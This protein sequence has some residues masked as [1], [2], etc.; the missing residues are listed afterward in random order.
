MELGDYWPYKLNPPENFLRRLENF[1]KKFKMKLGLVVVV[2]RT[3]AY[4][5]PK[6]HSFEDALNEVRK[7]EK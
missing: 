7:I 6:D 4:T 1:E 5:P 3:G 2:Y